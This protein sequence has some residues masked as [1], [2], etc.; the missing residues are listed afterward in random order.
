ME[1]GELATFMIA[2]CVV[3]ALLYHPSSS[4]GAL[5][6]SDVVR[7]LLTGIAMGLTAIAIVYS[8]WGKRSGAHFNPAVTL[9]FLRLGKVAPWDAAFYVF[10]QFA[11]GWAGVA[12][13]VAL[14]GDL[15]RHPSVNYVATVPGT[16]GIRIAFLSEFAMS[17]SLM[18]VVLTMSNTP[19]LARFTGVL[20]GALVAAYIAIEAPLSGMSLNPA[21][22]LGP[23]LVGHV[24]SA[25]WVYFIAPPLGML[26][27]AE[28]YAR[29]K[30][31]VGCAKLHH[32]NPLRCIFCEH[33]TEP[34][35]IVSRA[36][37]P[38]AT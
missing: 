35:I 15:I 10:A 29:V 21:R 14:L 8:P 36:Q 30:D 19:R 18:T 31:G 33:H 17:F 3:V 13:C 32:D 34:R 4:V 38:L 25:L 1:A 28:V 37:R 5:V 2:A 7:R 20:V 22:T 6:P 11:G 27:A 16:A 12:L 9:T 23:A 26:L 24:W